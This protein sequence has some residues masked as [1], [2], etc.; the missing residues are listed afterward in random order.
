M[1]RNSNIID[2][3]GTGTYLKV[4]EGG[5]V[6]TQSSN[7][8]PVTD[9]DLQIV[10]R[11]FLTLN[12]DGTTNSMLVDGSTTPQL[13]YVEASPDNDTYITSLSIVIQGL[14][15][16]LGDDFGGSSGLLTPLFTSLP[17]GCRLFY[18]D[19]NGEINIGTDLDTNFELVRLCQGNPNFGNNGNA[20]KVP[21]LTPE[22]KGKTTSDGYIPVLDFPEVFGFNYGLRLQRGTTNRLVFEINDDIRIQTDGGGLPDDAGFNIIVYGFERK[23]D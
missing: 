12:G 2:G 9:R 17:N 21:E 13:F 5:Y 19:K 10:Y 4:N 11:K 3:E 8:P 6:F 22:S 16:N 7:L 18:E 15:I 14:G 20:F 23:P 1:S